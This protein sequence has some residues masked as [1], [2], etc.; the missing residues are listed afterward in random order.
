[1]I[2]AATVEDIPALLAMGER[3][4]QL[5]KLDS[6]V[7][8]DPATMAETFRAMIEGG[9]PLF[10][11]ETGAIGATQTRHPFNA[12]HVVA[13]ELF[14][15]SEGGGGLALLDALL[16]HCEAHCNSLVMISLEAVDPERVARIYTRKGF[17]PLERSFVKVF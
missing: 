11:S 7:G 16:G 2:R 17:V 12:S 14:W 5:A 9:H 13:Q 3:F 10:I 4:S 6:H 8:Y 15:W 1:M